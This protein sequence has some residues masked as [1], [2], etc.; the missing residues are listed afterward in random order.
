MR[1]D[2]QGELA[3]LENMTLPELRARYAGV[4]G[5]ASRSRNRQG[6][7]RRILWRLQARAEGDLSERAQRRAAELADDAELR[8]YPP[9]GTPQGVGV[10]KRD[11]RLPAPGTVLTR[12]YKG[13]RRRNDG[14][15]PFHEYSKTLPPAAGQSVTCVLPFSKRMQSS[16][17]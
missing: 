4:V 10:P 2:V 3:A 7:V 5:E 14:S 12:L 9:T 15:L 17:P 8:L 16:Y 1:L 11:R 13:D 6:L